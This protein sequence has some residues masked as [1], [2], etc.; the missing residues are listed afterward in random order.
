MLLTERAGRTQLD[1]SFAMATPEIAEEMRGFIR[2]AGGEGTWDRLAEH[3]A[4]RVAGKEQFFIARSFDAGIEQ[5]YEAWA[6]PDQLAQWM[7]PTGATMQFLRTEPRVGGS[8]LY[9]MSFGG[10]AP[11]H[12]LVKYFTLEKPR[13][14]VYTQQFCDEQ[15]RIIRPPF[16][17]DWPLAMLT[18]VE[19][20]AEGAD[21]TRVTVRWEPQEASDAD[22]AEF[23]K[24]RAGM[25]M[26]WTGSFD[27]LEA[28][29]G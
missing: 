20:A 13:L 29:L 24:Q 2:K 7:P 10:G 23:V 18:T 9:A 11:M 8:S 28:V 3:L 4:Q 12:G 21:R 15:E 14:I 27:K 5:V 6:D 16:F 19:F 25:T 1:L 26:G 22:I 17:K